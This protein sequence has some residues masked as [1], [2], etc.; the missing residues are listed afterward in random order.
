[1]RK[2]Y[3]VDDL[4]CELRSRISREIM[5]PLTI[6]ERVPKTRVDSIQ[7]V[8]RV[9]QAFKKASD[10]IWKDVRKKINNKRG[11]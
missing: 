5:E 9:F 10:K 2:R 4:S 8:E 7:L 1:M 6:V 11:S 3:N